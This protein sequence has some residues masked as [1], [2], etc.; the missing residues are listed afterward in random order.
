[1]NKS[2]THIDIVFGNINQE[3][4]KSIIEMWVLDGLLTQEKAE[5][6]VNDVFAIRIKNNKIISVCTVKKQYFSNHGI[7]WFYSTST[8]KE[9]QKRKIPKNNNLLNITT[10]YLSTLKIANKPKGMIAILENKKINPKM[11]KWFAGWKYFGKDQYGYDIMYYNFD[12]S[13]IFN[14]STYI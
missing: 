12:N 4:K 9:E 10:K 1:M 2:E 3:L 7:Y 5:N 11:V 14:S 6:R 13:F 8:I